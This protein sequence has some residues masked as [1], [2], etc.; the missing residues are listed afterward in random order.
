MAQIIYRSF[1]ALLCCVLI[2]VSSFSQAFNGH[3]P[4]GLESGSPLGSYQ[5]GGL[6]SINYYNGNLSFNL[7][8]LQVG[9]RGG[10][11]YPITLNVESHWSYNFVPG[12]DGGDWFPEF[13]KW[14]PVSFKYMPG[15]LLRRG[16]L[17]SGNSCPEPPAVGP[18]FYVTKLTFI[19]GDG[20]ATELIDTIAD[21]KWRTS[22]CTWP[23]DGG[24]NRG[25]IFTSRDG[26]AT[27]FI[28]DVP[29]HDTP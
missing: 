20:T 27:T 10:A 16:T 2:E 15:V 21:G 26:S 14:P 28:S 5:T 18:V 19:A 11:G 22:Q 24:F 3:T 23:A 25:A 4:S 7:P 13:N 9:G 8:L 1:F 12:P 6:D 17:T 29:I